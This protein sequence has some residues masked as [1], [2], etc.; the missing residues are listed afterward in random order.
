[1]KKFLKLLNRKITN[2]EEA[3]AF[4]AGCYHL[5]G[6]GSQDVD[7][8][9]LAQRR[10]ILTSFH[11]DTSGADYVRLKSKT[12]HRQMFSAAEA[13]A[14]DQRI[15][16]CREMASRY[17]GSEDE[18]YELG[19]WTVIGIGYTIPTTKV[20]PFCDWISAP[21]AKEAAARV[22][23]DRAADTDYVDTAWTVTVVLKG[24][25]APEEIT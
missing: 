9:N 6:C 8:P 25:H 7:T 21:T 14:Y 5:L 18:F 15:S 13:K 12:F 22:L 2:L 1:M 4:V 20:S 17:M 24:R 10:H 16:E 3:E 23:K 11:P 19:C